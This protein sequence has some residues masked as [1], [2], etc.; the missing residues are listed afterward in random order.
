MLGM[1][2]M[3]CALLADISAV[4]NSYQKSIR[5]DKLSKALE[6]IKSIYG[7]DIFQLIS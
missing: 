1:N 5:F 6:E 4:Y 3:E 7:E 2:F